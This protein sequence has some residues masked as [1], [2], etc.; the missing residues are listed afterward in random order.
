MRD[1]YVPKSEKEEA[2]DLRRQIADA[3]RSGNEDLA[4][5]L[6]AEAEF[7]GI[8]SSKMEK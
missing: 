2:E 7:Y 8:K 5:E 4:K 6:M 1:Y 3:I